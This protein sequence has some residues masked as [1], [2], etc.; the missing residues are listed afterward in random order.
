MQQKA[1][2]ELARALAADE[3]LAAAYPSRSSEPES[4]IPTGRSRSSSGLR[5]MVHYRIQSTKR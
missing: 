3:A 2:S 5:R 1:V 4:G